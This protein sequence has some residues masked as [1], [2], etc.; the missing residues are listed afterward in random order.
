[1]SHP[2]GGLLT[3]ELELRFVIDVD[4]SVPRHGG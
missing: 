1:M 3:L 2:S 4:D